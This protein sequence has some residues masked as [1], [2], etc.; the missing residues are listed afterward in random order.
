MNSNY[1]TLQVPAPTPNNLT[2]TFWDALKNDQTLKQQFCQDCS[3]WVFYPREVCP[4]C[5]SSRL[6]WRESTGKGTI[7][8]YSIVHR[9]GHFAWQE[10]APYAVVLIEL[11]EGPTMLS[12]M[13][14]IDG[15]E[16]K[17]GSPVE[18]APIELGGY[19]LPFFKLSV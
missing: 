1:D 19:V 14:L 15:Q 9:A 4:H 8:T 18:L 17:V 5:W 6:E 10:V 13:Q 11:V 12:H 3:K 16:I 7:K 2:K